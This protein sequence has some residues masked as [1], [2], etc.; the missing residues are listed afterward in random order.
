MDEGRQRQDAQ[1]IIVARNV[2]HLLFIFK[3]KLLYIGCI[4]QNTNQVTIKLTCNVMDMLQL[5]LERQCSFISF[6]TYFEIFPWWEHEFFVTFDKNRF[7]ISNNFSE[8]FSKCVS[9][10]SV[11]INARSDT[12]F[13][14]F[15]K[16]GSVEG[17]SQFKRISSVHEEMAVFTSQWERSFFFPITLPRHSDWWSNWNL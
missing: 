8:V 12:N 15:V 17:S 2:T 3:L 4:P 10:N 16:A 7:Y 11:L 9:W 1:W 5:F 13:M 14:I 6:I